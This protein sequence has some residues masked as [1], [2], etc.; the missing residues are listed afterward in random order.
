MTLPR[1]PLVL[2]YHGVGSRPAA[3]D[4]YNL[5]V[6][7]AALRAQLR[8]L[9]DRGWRPLRLV[10]YLAQLAG[11]A[12][13]DHRFLVTFDDGYR[14]VHDAAMP[15]LAELG[16]PATVFLCAGMLGG[17]SGWMPDLPDEP[18]VTR[19]EAL[20]LRDGG[21]DIGLHG[22]D[23]TVLAGLPAA[24]LRRQTGLAADRLK[25][26]LGERPVAFAYPCGVHDGP[27][28]AAVAAA[29]MRV[30]FATYRSAGRLA[31]PRVDVNATD[32]GRTFGLKTVRGYPRLRQLTGT[33]PG[34][35]PTLRGLLSGTAGSPADPPAGGSAGTSGGSA[36]TSRS[37]SGGT[38]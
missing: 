10:E 6:T 20:A 29:G 21:L 12:R 2:M 5:F 11:P 36:A 1:R 18:L 13:A 19:A 9:L 37:G 14:S 27:A 25:E 30:A 34:L 26:E 23:H 3:A 28:R 35:R 31:V 16:V 32:N 38:D 24:E 7:T 8:W 22:M 4:P 15:L 33:V 17:R